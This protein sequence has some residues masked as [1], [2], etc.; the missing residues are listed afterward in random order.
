MGF[1]MPLLR[2]MLNLI[3]PHRCF[4]CQQTVPDTEPLS[5]CP[6]C[7]SELVTEPT[8]TCPRCASRVGP[9]GG[10]TRCAK[11]S[12]RFASATRL[13]EYD[14]VLRELLLRCKNAGQEGVAEHLGRLFARVRLLDK[15]TLAPQAVI[16]V[17]LH[18]T[19]RLTRQYNQAEAMAAGI[20]HELKLP[21]ITNALIRHRRTPRLADQ[22]KTE[23]QEI[24]KEA[25]RGRK[26]R[27]LNGMRVLLVDDILTTGATANAASVAILGAGAAQVDLAVLA[28]R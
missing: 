3:W 5:F 15:T 12:F 25:F 4:L 26:T 1:P 27:K 16:P 20:A 22:S 7:I 10:C 24:M 17:P 18:W 13:G 23:R 11:E 19:R 2:P 14:G 9:H 28:H 21:L 8:P 6:V